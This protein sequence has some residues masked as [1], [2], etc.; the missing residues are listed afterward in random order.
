MPAIKKY[1]YAQICSERGLKYLYEKNPYLYVEDGFGFTHKTC[2]NSFAIGGEIGFR[3]LIGSKT[4]Y[5]KKLFFAKFKE[6]VDDRLSFEGFEYKKSLQYTNVTCVVHGI[7]RTKPNWLLNR[8]HHCEQCA[9]E[10]RSERKKHSVEDFIILAKKKHGDKYGYDLVVYD[11]CRK[12][13]LI[14]CKVHGS[15]Y[16]V[17]YYHLAGNG[18]P[19]CGYLLGGYGAKDYARACPSGSSIYLMKLYNDSEMFYKIGISKEAGK[20]A[21]IISRETGY[22]VD[23]LAEMRFENAEKAFYGEKYLHDIFKFCSYSPQILFQGHTECFSYIC[24]REF[25]ELKRIAESQG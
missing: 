7:Y 14:T 16:Q 10:T 18:C 9:E 20:R 2:R 21:K 22:K 6:S 12:P 25:E 24:V 8:G 4:E 13:V 17:P 1:D 3:S 11:G 19:E 15:F 23:V 5:F